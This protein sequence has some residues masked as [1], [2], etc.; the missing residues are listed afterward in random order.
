M[1]SSPIDT[2]AA[3]DFVRDL[4][5]VGRLRRERTRIGIL[6]NRVRHN[7]RSFQALQRFLTSLN[8][9]VV[10]M[11]RDSQCYVRAM[12]QGLGAHELD[13]SRAWR[14]RKTWQRVVNWLEAEVPS[15]ARPVAQG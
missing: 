4:F 5:L 12:E 6:P 15:T 10:D 7:T 11:L 2:H 13:E 9:P 8:I 1:L 3:A 14:E